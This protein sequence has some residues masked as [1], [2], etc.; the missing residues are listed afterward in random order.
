MAIL[1]M[2]AKHK[3]I[4]SWPNSSSMRITRLMLQYLATFLGVQTGNQA[5][6][7]AGS[8]LH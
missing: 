1:A 5:V 8:V 2:F 6:I 3:I 4:L 7:L